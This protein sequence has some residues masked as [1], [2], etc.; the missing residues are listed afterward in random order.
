MGFQFASIT[1]KSKSREAARA[2]TLRQARPQLRGARTTGQPGSS[3][4]PA[5]GPPVPSSSKGDTGSHLFLQ[6]SWVSGMK[7]GRWLG[8]CAQ[9]SSGPFRLCNQETGQ[10]GGERRKVGRVLHPSRSH[11]PDPLTLCLLMPSVFLSPVSVPLFC[12]CQQVIL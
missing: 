2:T 5:G 7:A 12:F 9:P 10:M 3:P 4:D 6:P 1:T 8:L 11:A